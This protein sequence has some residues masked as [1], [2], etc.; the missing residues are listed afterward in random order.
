MSYITWF[1]A[2]NK[3]LKKMIR[4]AKPG[5]FWKKIYFRNILLHVSGSEQLQLNERPKTYLIFRKRSPAKVLL[6]FAFFK[7]KNEQRK[8]EKERSKSLLQNARKIQKNLQPT[9]RSYFSSVKLT[10]DLW[11][12]SWYCLPD[13]LHSFHTLAHC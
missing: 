11:E 9:L 1:C 7:K 13:K 6:V 5:C 10:F 12:I 8:K 4:T 3:P 2:K